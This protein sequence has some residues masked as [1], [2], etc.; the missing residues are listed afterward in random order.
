[1]P[2]GT[3]LAICISFSAESTWAVRFLRCDI[4]LSTFVVQ[5]REEGTYHGSGLLEVSTVLNVTAD[6]FSCSICD[7]ETAIARQ[8]ELQADQSGEGGWVIGNGHRA[9]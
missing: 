8:Y 7:L 6:R 2:Q 3:G 4:Y 1:M 5:G 9:T